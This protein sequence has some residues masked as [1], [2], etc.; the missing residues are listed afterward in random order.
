M[1]N[2]AEK[3]WLPIVLCPTD[4]VNRALM[5]PDGSEVVGCHANPGGWQ[6]CEVIAYDMPTKEVVRGGFLPMELRP[7]PT[8]IERVTGSRTV[9][10]TVYGKLPDGIYPSHFRPNDTVY[11]IASPSKPDGGTV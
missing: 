4:G 8:A 10:M 2:L 3:G 5:L 9:S 7:T 11:G 6:T 1:T